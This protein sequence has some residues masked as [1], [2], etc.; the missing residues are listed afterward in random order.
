MKNWMRRSEYEDVR[1]MDHG[2]TEE[3]AYLASE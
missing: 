3:D 1:I 2:T